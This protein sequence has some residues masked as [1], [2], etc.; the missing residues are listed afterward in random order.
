[1]GRSASSRTGLGITSDWSPPPPAASLSP[2]VEGERGEAP[3][4]PGRRTDAC[5]AAREA[6]AVTLSSGG[7]GCA[8]ETWRPVPCGRRRCGPRRAPRA[9]SSRD[10]DSCP[11]LP[12]WHLSVRCPGG[13]EDARN[14][15]HSA[16]SWPGVR[17]GPVPTGKAGPAGARR[18]CWV[19]RSA[20]SPPWPL[21]PIF[22]PAPRAQPLSRV[23]P[24]GR[25]RTPSEPVLQS[26]VP[27]APAS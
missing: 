17:R 6:F 10:T 24:G 9:S 7:G 23:L 2:A 14:S 4:G 13:E 3:G 22:T 25:L 15:G 18:A 26:P 20:C 12:V 27:A 5:G 19:R 11:R 1:M 21:L 16:V 8:G